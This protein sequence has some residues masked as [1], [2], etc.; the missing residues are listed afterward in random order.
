MYEYE[1]SKCA[2]IERRYPIG[3]APG[4]DK[5]PTCGKEARRV[6]SPPYLNRTSRPVA[7]A[8]EQSYKSAH[9]PEVV[10]RDTS[11]TQQGE[12]RPA[13]NPEVKKLVGEKAWK[14]VREARHPAAP[15]N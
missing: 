14:N 2:L 9:D 12:Q 13:V 5:C 4:T 6:Y 8:L 1:C 15:A 3:S 11:G 7:T 10:K